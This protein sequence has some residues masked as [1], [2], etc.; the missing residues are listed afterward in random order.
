MEHVSACG[1]DI[2][3]DYAHT[4][5]ALEN[6][7]RTLR[8]L[9]RGRLIAVFGC[10]GDRDRGKR[11]QMGEIAA[12]YA[13]FTYVTSDN[14]RSEDPMAIIEDIAAGMGD[15]RKALHKDRREAI[16]EAIGTAV[17]GDV[18]LIAGK[19]HENYQ[20]VGTEILPFDD[21]QVAREALSQR[22]LINP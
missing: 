15:A 21:L 1:I 7:L 20:I 16:F 9:A 17:S 19:G 6:A 8:E 2:I 14:P 18:I 3:V 13:D 12:R 10:G 11:P 4:P 5:D 22:E